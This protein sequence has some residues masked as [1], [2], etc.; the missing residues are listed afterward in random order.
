MEVHN[1]PTVINDIPPKTHECIALG[2]TLNMQGT[3]K[4]FCLDMGRVLQR[5][6][7]I[8][9][10]DLNRVTMEVNDWYKK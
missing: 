6:D 7:I 2:P 5:S 8:P 4:V 9:M 10:L 1:K 3:Q